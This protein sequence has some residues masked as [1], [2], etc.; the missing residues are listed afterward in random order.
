[1]I[2]L[3]PENYGNRITLAGLYWTTG[4]PAEKHGDAGR[5]RR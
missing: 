3:E 2:E 4:Q 1:V 5:D